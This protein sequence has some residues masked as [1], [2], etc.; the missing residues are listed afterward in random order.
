[1]QPTTL[2]SRCGKVRLRLKL[3][4]EGDLNRGAHL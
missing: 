3:T 1:M 2:D 4:G